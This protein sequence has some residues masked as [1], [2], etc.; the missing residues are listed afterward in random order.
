MKTRILL[1]FVILSTIIIS[2]CRTKKEAGKS[3][4]PRPE[5]QE[6]KL[7][8]IPWDNK[9]SISNDCSISFYNEFE[10]NI[11]GYKPD[12]VYKVVD[13]QVR[14]INNSQGADLKIPKNTPGSIIT[15]GVIRNSSGIVTGIKV[16]HFEENEDCYV[17]YSL[18]KGG[19]NFFYLES[20]AVIIFDGK[21]QK[22]DLSIIGEGTGCRAFY[23]KGYDDQSKSTQKT[24]TGKIIP[25]VQE[26]P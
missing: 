20:K 13:G 2:S 24:A 23:D 18:K 4:E 14:E 15:G 5:P 16:N 3:P 17:V 7:S 6:I 25:G 8:L 9:L 11:V 1:I 12:Y 19:G 10:I 22:V 26:I 21:E